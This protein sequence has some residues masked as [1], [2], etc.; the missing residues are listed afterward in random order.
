M[1]GWN[2]GISTM[3]HLKRIGSMK[4]ANDRLKFRCFP[5]KISSNWLQRD[6]WFRVFDKWAFQCCPGYQLE[7][8]NATQFNSNTIAS[9]S[10]TFLVPFSPPLRTTSLLLIRLDRHSLTQTEHKINSENI[11]NWILNRFVG[12]KHLKSEKMSRWGVWRRC[13]NTMMQSVLIQCRLAPSFFEF[14]EY[15]YSWV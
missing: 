2:Q 1:H 9:K 14:N 7:C 10:R 3:W 4:F 5:F 6:R 8:S 11:G 13:C 12:K 15:S